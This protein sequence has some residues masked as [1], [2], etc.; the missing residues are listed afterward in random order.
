MRLAGEDKGVRLAGEDKGVRNRVMRRLVSQYDVQALF[1][2]VPHQSFHISTTHSDHGEPP[3]VQSQLR[4]GGVQPL[5]S[6]YLRKQE[7]VQEQR[8]FEEVQLVR[9]E[10]QEALGAKFAEEILTT[11]DDTRGFAEGAAYPVN[12]VL[13]SAFARNNSQWVFP[14]YFQRKTESG[15]SANNAGDMFPLFTIPDCAPAAGVQLS[16]HKS[17][18][19]TLFE[20]L[21][22]ECRS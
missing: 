6:N 18:K 1:G 5:G 10:A 15:K 17:A 19:R 22:L 12:A 4:P 11:P 16:S 8:E 21:S 3:P 13:C 7:L 20:G 14:F 2:D 9:H